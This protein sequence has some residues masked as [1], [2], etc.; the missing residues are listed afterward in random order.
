MDYIIERER[1]TFATGWPLHGRN[2]A[3][4]QFYNLSQH[5]IASSSQTAVI[6][7]NNQLGVA[8]SLLNVSKRMRK[9]F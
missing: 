1:V 8:V 4:H 7:P 3:F 5:T 2:R 9:I 6:T